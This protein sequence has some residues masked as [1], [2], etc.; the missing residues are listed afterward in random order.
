MKKLLAAVSMIALM[1]A[2]C[3]AS[4][5]APSPRP[6]D[7]G[8]PTTA[9]KMSMGQFIT[10]SWKIKSMQT[11]GGESQDVS[12]LGLTVRFDGERMQAKVCNLM[13][14]KYTLKDDVMVFG[15]VESTLMFCEGK[16][17]EVEVAFSNGLEKGYKMVKQGDNLVMQGAAVFVLQREG[18]PI[19]D[20]GKVY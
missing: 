7:N 17:G 10:G 11:V 5:P 15:P 6:T 14:G 4:S 8:E 20:D 1:G 13:G 18:E 3:S 9:P 16:P 12:G 2:G 19:T